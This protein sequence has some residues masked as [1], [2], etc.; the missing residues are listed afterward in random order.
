M[1][2]WGRRLDALV[3]H[4]IA[5]FARTT[6]QARSFVV[7]AT[8]SSMAIMIGRQSYRVKPGGIQV[9]ARP[10]YGSVPGHC[11]VCCRCAARRFRL[12]R[13]PAPSPEGHLFLS[14]KPRGVQCRSTLQY[15]I[16]NSRLW[17]ECAMPVRTYSL[18]Q[19]GQL[20]AAV[21]RLFREA[22]R[23]YGVSWQ[24]VVCGPVP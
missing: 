2:L 19:P 22:S 14:L 20:S 12:V 3:S 15:V 8:S 11:E 17:S 1:R 9:K 16:P 6:A 5:G 13:Q 18:G 10:E 7:I 4:R 21:L 23:F 24:H